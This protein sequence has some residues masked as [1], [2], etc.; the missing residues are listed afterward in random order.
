MRLSRARIDEAEVSAELGDGAARAEGVGIL[1]NEREG[2]I[3]RVLEGSSL[4]LAA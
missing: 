3:I 2:E 4:R 1:W